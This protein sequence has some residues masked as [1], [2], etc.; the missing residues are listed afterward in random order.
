MV[1]F[2]GDVLKIVA[3][4]FSINDTAYGEVRNC[5]ETVGPMY[6]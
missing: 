3:A 6:Q 1:N 5:F 4:G 2:S